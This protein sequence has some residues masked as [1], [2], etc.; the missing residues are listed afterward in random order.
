MDEPAA[1]VR[2]PVDLQPDPVARRCDGLE[3]PDDL[4]RPRVPFSD[5]ITEDI[6]G[7]RDGINVFRNPAWH[8]RLGKRQLLG[9]TRQCG[10]RQG[11]EDR[12]KGPREEVNNGKLPMAEGTGIRAGMRDH[13]KRRSGLRGPAEEINRLRPRRTARRTYPGKAD[14]VP[15]TYPVDEGFRLGRRLCRVLCT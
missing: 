14:S 4:V 11:C 10:H 2:H 9:S 15:G 12:K 5:S 6:L 7:T 3:V 1:L 13:H 8:E